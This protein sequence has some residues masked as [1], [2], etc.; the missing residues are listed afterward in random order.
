MN[1]HLICNSQSAYPYTLLNNYPALDVA[2]PFQ[3]FQ[4]DFRFQIES[5]ARFSLLIWFQEWN[6][7]Q[8][9]LQ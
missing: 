3:S 9:L 6:F 1:N 4:D 5:L 2:K 7:L 8:R